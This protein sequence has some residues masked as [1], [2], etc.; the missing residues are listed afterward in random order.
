VGIAPARPRHR[1]LAARAQFLGA[2][3]SAIEHALA[4]FGVRIEEYP[5]TPARLFALI[6]GRRE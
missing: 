2:I 6:N 1:R 3:I 4:P 5:M